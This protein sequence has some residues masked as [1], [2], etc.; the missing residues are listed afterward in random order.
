MSTQPEPDKEI[1]AITAVYGSL[2]ELDAGAQLRV[3]EYVI[4]KLNL[5]LETPTQKLAEDQ[6]RAEISGDF[7]DDRRN[8]REDTTIDSS[9]DGFTGISPVA[10]KWIQRNGLRADQLSAI[11]SLGGD[12]IDLIT[13]KVPGK[14]KRGKMRSVFLLKGLAAYLSGGAARIAHDKVKETCLH[15]GAYDQANFA[16][17][18][19]EFASEISGSK[20]SGYALTPRGLANA[21]AVTREM[22]GLNQN[23]QAK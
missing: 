17:H 18:L 13:D 3:I 1:L 4:K 14:S 12:E 6:R 9:I 2:K 16:K 23:P 19:K 5:T 21:A 11:F 22:L 10:Q 7:R 15:Y 8:D 20:E